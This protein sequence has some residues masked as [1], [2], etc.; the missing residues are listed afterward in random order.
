M[1]SHCGMPR[2]SPADSA[3][4]AASSGRGREIAETEPA[5]GRPT[6]FNFVV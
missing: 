4:E 3:V 1:S 2:G 5:A 6:Y